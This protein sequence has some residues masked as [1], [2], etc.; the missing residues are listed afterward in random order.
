MEKLPQEPKFN[1]VDAIKNFN[2]NQ[3]VLKLS[4]DVLDKETLELKI[5]VLN[6]DFVLDTVNVFQFNKNNIDECK[7]LIQKL[8]D[9]IKYFEKAKKM[10]ENLPDTPIDLKAFVENKNK[11]L[12]N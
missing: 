3:K 7:K 10:L 5:N 2:S 12:K 9:N 11:K 4:L 6:S 8:E 1:I